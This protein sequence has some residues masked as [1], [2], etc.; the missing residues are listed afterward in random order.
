LQ[1]SDGCQGKVLGGNLKNPFWIDTI[2]IWVSRP[3][4]DGFISQFSVQGWIFMLIWILILINFFL[5][6][7]I[8]IYEAFNLVIL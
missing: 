2:P 1:A 7:G 6:A 8:G 3:N 5:W 4:A